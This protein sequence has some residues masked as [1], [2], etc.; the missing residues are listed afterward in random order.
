[1]LFAREGAKVLAVDCN[2]DAANDTVARIHAEEGEAEAA[3]FLA[4]YAAGFIT[5]AVLPVDGGMSA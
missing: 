1:M 3:L 4:S 2:L 5:G